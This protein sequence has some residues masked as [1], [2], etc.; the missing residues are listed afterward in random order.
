MKFAKPLKVLLAVSAFALQGAALAAPILDQHSPNPSR[1]GGFCHLNGCAQSFQ[2]NAGTI[3]GAGIYIHPDYHAP[4][5]DV[6]LSIYDA[7]TNGNLIASGMVTAV[8]S[9]SGWIDAFWSPVTIA[10]GSQ[11]YLQLSSTSR[12]LVAAY[13]DGDYVN[14]IAWFQTDPYPTY[15]LAFRTYA[16]A[17]VPEPAPLALLGLGILGVAASRRAGRRPLTRCA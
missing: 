12:D 9:E 14:G 10:A 13:S 5:G 4:A 1:G 3:A 16:G 17:V 15:D 8:A 2:Q 6:T 7:L 11:Y